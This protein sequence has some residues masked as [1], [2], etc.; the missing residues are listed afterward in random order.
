MGSAEKYECQ[1][2]TSASRLNG[3]GVVDAAQGWHSAGLPN[4]NPT[5]LMKIPATSSARRSRFA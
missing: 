3:L 5:K 4:R 2:A 1:A